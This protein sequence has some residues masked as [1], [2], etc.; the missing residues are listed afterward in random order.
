MEGVVSPP[1]SPALP[2][3]SLQLRYQLGTSP[4]V[5]ALTTKPVTDGRPHRVNITRLHRT[6]YTQVWGLRGW[7]GAQAGWEEVQ[8]MLMPCTSLSGGLSPRHGAAVLP[9]CGQQ[10]GLP[11]KP[12]PGA[13]DG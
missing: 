8:R 5:F 3:G 10:A 4:Y 11:Q 9:V 12:V 1:K 6:L 2:T 7:E 13:R